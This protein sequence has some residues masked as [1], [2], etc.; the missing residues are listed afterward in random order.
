MGLRNG[1]SLGIRKKHIRLGNKF[2]CVE[3]VS[4][5]RYIL[6]LRTSSKTSLSSPCLKNPIIRYSMTKCKFFHSQKSRDKTC[7]TGTM[8]WHT[9][10]KNES[11]MCQIL[12]SHIVAVTPNVGL[13]PTTTRLTILSPT[14]LTG[15]GIGEFF[16]SYIAVLTRLWILLSPF[17]SW[18]SLVASGPLR[19]SPVQWE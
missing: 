10:G 13:E 5:P 2:D 6:V 11:S 4:V 12:S 17:F 15:L 18:S 16:R 1:I 9:L 3:G 7:S 14:E 19:G 8:M